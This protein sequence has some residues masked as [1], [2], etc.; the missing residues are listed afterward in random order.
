MRQNDRAKQFMPFAALK[1]Y[2]EMVEEQALPTP[3]AKNQ[4]GNKKLQSA[5]KTP[6]SNQNSNAEIT[7]PKTHKKTQK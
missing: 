7:T 4:K 1:G 5:K 2:E 6:C 3:Q